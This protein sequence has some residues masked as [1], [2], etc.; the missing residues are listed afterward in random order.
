MKKTR[1]QSLLA[2]AFVVLLLSG[3]AACGEEPPTAEIVQV[4][5]S[6]PEPTSAPESTS[7][8]EPTSAPQPTFG[9]QPPVGGQVVVDN[10]DPSFSIE[11]GDW[12]S[13]SGG[14]CSGTPYGADFRYA[15]I[16]CTSCRARFE[17]Q[18]LA[19]GQYEVWAWWPWGEDRAT[20]TS[21]TLQGGGDAITIQVDQRNS[22][23][24]WYSLGDFYFDAGLVTIIVQGS[25]SGFA[26]A[27]AVALTPAGSGLPVAGQVAQLPTQ[28]PPKVPT[29]QVEPTSQPE[30]PAAPPA[31]PFSPPPAGGMIVVDYTCTDLSK[32]PDEW[33]ER[34]KALTIHYAHTSHGSQIVTG[35]EW[36]QNQDSRYAVAVRNCASDVGLEGGAGTLR[37]CDGNP[38]VDYVTPEDYWNSDYG[39]ENTR[40]VV[41]TGLFNISGWIWCG[42]QSENDPETV[43]RYL[44]TITQ[45][46]T[47]FPGTRFIYFTGHTDGGGDI[48]ARN[49]DMVRQYVQ[50]N[51][52]ILFDF[53]SFESYDPSG[54]YYP[55]ASDAC[56]WCDSWC[57]SHP[58][59][60]RNLDQIGD[61]AHTHPLQCK[62]KA[63]AWWWLMARLAG[64]DGR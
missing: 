56:D 42:Q 33:L 25:D 53:A 51:G 57:Q 4:D 29:A 12:G 55:N 39:L 11:E 32:I 2:L 58:E 6:A 31:T 1:F 64:W 21:F 28:E 14:D 60:C 36:L 27:D 59:D 46:E 47:E 23:D 24:G 8:P 44:D 9:G 10:A 54:K 26:N 61:C 41:R 17:L 62:L 40:A 22:G 43:Q 30:A 50:A 63:Q 18:V 37:L 48:L 5:T 52:K 13:C 35:L 20:D 34:A 7:L 38:P 16:G 49:N 19:A 45:L 15:E 3:L